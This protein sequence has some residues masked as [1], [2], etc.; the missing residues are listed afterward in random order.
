MD[1]GGRR[2]GAGP[3]R[4]GVRAERARGS[5]RVVWGCE[6]K[7]RP[8]PGG[9]GEGLGGRGGAGGEGE[10]RRQIW[11]PHRRPTGRVKATA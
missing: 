11:A 2:A 4:R 5:V 8:S 7:K 6:G 9:V 3:A 1:E 10:V